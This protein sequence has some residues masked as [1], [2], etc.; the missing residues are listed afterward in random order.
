MPRRRGTKQSAESRESIFG[1]TFVFAVVANVLLWAAFPPFNFSSLAWFVPATWLYLVGS[2]QL[3][4]RKP[5]WVIWATSALAWGFILEGVGRAYWANYM[6]LVILGSYLAIYQVLLVWISRIAV[7]CWRVPIVIAAPIVW[8]G[9]ELAR[10]H[11]FTG[12]GIGLLGHTQ[13]RTTWLIQIADLFGAYA[14]TFLMVFVAACILQ[15]ICLKPRVNTRGIDG[16]QTLRRCLPV[17]L[18]TAALVFAYGYGKSRIHEP[19][20]DGEPIKVALIQGTEDSMLDLV[21][22]EAM[23]RAR[24][25][26]RQYWQLTLDACDDHGDLALIVWPESVLSGSLPQVLAANDAEPRPD[27][28]LTH[29]DFHAWL[30]DHKMAF[31]DKTHHL[32]EAIN[33]LADDRRDQRETYLLG[34]TDT[35][36]FVGDRDMTYNSALLISPSGDVVDCY[37]KMHRV[38][39]GEFVPLGDTFPWL[40]RLL[41]IGR[42]LTPGHSPTM[43]D[44]HGTRISPSIC[45]ESTVPHLMRR[46]FVQLGRDGKAPEVLV[47]LTN[48]GWFWGSGILDLHLACAV[49]RAVELR[50]PMLIAANTGITAWI[51]SNGTIRETLPRREPGF[52]VAEV[53][54]SRRRSVYQSVGD[55]AAWL[56]LLFCV[57]IV[58]HTAWKRWRSRPCSPN[59]SAVSGNNSA[60]HRR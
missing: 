3:Q 8:M 41:P 33:Q 34:G 56:C 29:D 32:A 15:A 24:D 11:F 35:I 31:R 44:V 12:F 10:A 17:G 58:C 16:V 42:G 2:E 28:N 50:R 5:Y 26:Y 48:D 21:P 20:G 30:N 51:D 4:R 40:Y 19:A 55:T 46:Q 43:F 22:E 18:A 23:Q 49:F 9:L 13:F 6:G 59:E 14:V 37:H 57:S 53:Q 36:M 45:F 7:W 38:M 47:N 54:S 27:S 25:T 52:V 39:L 1:S 60:N